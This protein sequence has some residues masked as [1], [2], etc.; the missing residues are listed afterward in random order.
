MG[1][2]MTIMHTAMIMQLQAPSSARF[3]SQQ[4]LQNRMFTARIATTVTHTEHL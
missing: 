2:R 4:L 1:T 3:L